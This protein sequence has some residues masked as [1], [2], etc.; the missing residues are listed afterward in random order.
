[1]ETRPRRATASRAAVV[2]A[3]RAPNSTGRRPDL[4]IGHATGGGPASPRRLAPESARDRSTSSPLCEESSPPKRPSWCPMSRPPDG[5]GRARARGTRVATE[6]GFR[7]EGPRTVWLRSPSGNEAHLKGQEARP[8]KEW[9]PV[10]RTPASLP[11]AAQSKAVERRWRRATGLKREVLPSCPPGRQ[12][13]TRVDTGGP[14]IW[15]RGANPQSR[16]RRA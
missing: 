9:K 5:G 13:R 4:R 1:V 16:S 7:A 12:R 15:S 11:I 10:R 3:R 8:P 14:F 2:H 6:S